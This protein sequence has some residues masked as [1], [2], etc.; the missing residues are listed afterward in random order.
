M[1][2]LG[3]FGVLGL[4]GAPLSLQ[5]LARTLGVLLESCVCHSVVALFPGLVQPNLPFLLKAIKN[6]TEGRRLI[7]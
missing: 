4:S 6:E 2:S 5:L 3:L 7:Q 1:F